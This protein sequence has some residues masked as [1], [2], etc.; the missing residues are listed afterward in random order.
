MPSRPGDGDPRLFRPM[1][2][3]RLVRHFFERPVYQ[4]LFL[5]FTLGLFISCS[6]KMAGATPSVI[7]VTARTS[8][9]AH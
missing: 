9:A 6:V 3:D 7:D 8:S 5:A 4:R 2:F 1:D